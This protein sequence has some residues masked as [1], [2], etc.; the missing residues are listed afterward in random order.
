MS[1]LSLSP[2]RLFLFL[3]ESTN[4]KMRLSFGR[5]H[6]P[7]ATLEPQYFREEG[8]SVDRI[9]SKRQLWIAPRVSSKGPCGKGLVP[10][11]ALV[12]SGRALREGKS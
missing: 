5:A 4:L 12:G 8:G 1:H 7:Q 2:A 3:G 10:S 11:M 6:V 9:S